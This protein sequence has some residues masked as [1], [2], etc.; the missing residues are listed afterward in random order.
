MA[1]WVTLLSF[2]LSFTFVSVL[3]LIWLVFS[4]FTRLL[5]PRLTSELGHGHLTWETK[6]VAVEGWWRYMK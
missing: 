4:E 3:Y 2:F 1:T 6:L 5:L